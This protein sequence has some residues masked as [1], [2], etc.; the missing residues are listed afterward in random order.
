MQEVRDE[1]RMHSR[2]IRDNLI[3]LVIRGGEGQLNNRDMAM[4]RSTLNKVNKL[5]VTLDLLRFSRIE[6]ALL[7]IIAANITWPVGISA[8]VEDI[9]LKWEDEL[10]PI[11]DLR[12]DLWAPGGRLEGVR[13]INKWR[14]V[15]C[16]KD[17]VSL[18]GRLMVVS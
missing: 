12:A 13:K 9:L 7:A 15:N 16:E 4:L 8:Q 5:P 14:D 18:N 2:Y 1:L 11:H 10:G 3:P 6:K 17:T